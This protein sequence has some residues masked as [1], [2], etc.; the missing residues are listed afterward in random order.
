MKGDSLV[1]PIVSAS[2][3]VGESNFGE[4]KKGTVESLKNI[5]C[6]LKNLY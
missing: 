3:N 1:N 2:S 5:I 4:S 6:F